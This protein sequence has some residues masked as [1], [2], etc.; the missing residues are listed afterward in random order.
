MTVQ[1]LPFKQENIKKT[2]IRNLLESEFL[3]SLNWNLFIS[4]GCFLKLDLIL[5]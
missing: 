2:P 5:E 4:L 1:F 3:V